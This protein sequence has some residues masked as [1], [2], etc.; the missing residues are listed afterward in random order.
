MNELK[1]AWE[2][3][4]NHKKEII[5]ECSD[6]SFYDDKEHE[7]YTQRQVIKSIE[8]DERLRMYDRYIN[9]IREQIELHKSKWNTLEYSH[10]KN[11]ICYIKGLINEAESLGIIMP[12]DI[13]ADI[14]LI[15]CNLSNKQRN[16]NFDIEIVGNTNGIEN[17]SMQ[18]LVKDLNV[19]F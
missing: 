17:N 16:K 19:K 3:E 14:Y 4:I 9:E 5:K 10:L 1:E 8:A 18:M 13:E 11:S 7:E 12:N 2:Q 6:I 15:E